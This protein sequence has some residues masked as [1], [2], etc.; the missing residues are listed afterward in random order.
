MPTA[1]APP[2]QASDRSRPKTI[3]PIHQPTVA[4]NQMAGILGAEPALE[5]RFEQ[6]SALRA[7]RE[8]HRQHGDGE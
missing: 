1:A 4:R 3:Q 8:N 6:I 7:Y 5:E 2:T